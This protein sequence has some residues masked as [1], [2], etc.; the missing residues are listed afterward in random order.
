[1]IGP[2]PYVFANV[3]HGI[4]ALGLTIE[5]PYP[6]HTLVNL[7]FLDCMDKSYGMPYYLEW[8]PMYFNWNSSGYRVLSI[9]VPLWLCALASGVP[10]AFAW[11]RH[12]RRRRRERAGSCPRC[13]YD[14]AG[15][16]PG[17]GGRIRCPECGAR[18]RAKEGAGLEAR[19][20]RGERRG[21]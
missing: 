15:I 12:R 21:V 2:G 20:E 5:S 3:Y 7:S 13:G 1:L 14:L 9:G 16:Q 11:R 10:A 8:L 19:A 18:P 6:R 17:D 4:L